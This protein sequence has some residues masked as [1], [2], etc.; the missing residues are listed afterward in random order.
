MDR[1]GWMVGFSN[2]SV[3]VHGVWGM[4]R[5]GWMVGF[6]NRSVTVQGVWGMD[7]AGWMAGFSNRSLTVHGVWGTD[8]Q[9]A[10][11]SGL[12][13][14]GHNTGREGNEGRNERQVIHCGRFVYWE[15]GYTEDKER[16]VR[17]A[18]VVLGS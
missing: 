13:K 7:R 5:A 2:R 6:S 17:S 10:R 8:R 14:E 11:L 4:D 16:C 1:A 9:V 15:L 3:T 12:R 18:S